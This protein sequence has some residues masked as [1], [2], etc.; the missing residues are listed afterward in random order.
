[1]SFITKA[2]FGSPPPAPDYA[3]AAQVQGQNNIAAAQKEA[4]LNRLNE[5]TPYGSVNYFQGGDGQPWS[6]QISLSPGQQQLYDLE[7]GNQIASQQ[8]AQ[9]LQGRL[10]ASVGQP[11]SF[12][13]IG[14]SQGLDK[15]MDFAQFTG[16][17]PGQ[18]LVDGG[19]RMGRVG[20]GPDPLAVENARARDLGTAANYAGGSDAVRDALYRQ[21]SRLRE[22]D[23]DR[24]RA[25]LDL[26]LRNQGLLPG[27]EIYDQELSRLQRSHGLERNDLADRAILA[28]GA[29]QSRLAGLDMNL[30]AQ[31][32][33]QEN[34][35]FQNR[36]GQIGQAFGQNLQGMGFNNAAAQAEFG[37]RLSAAGF[38]NAATQRGFE[39]Q[40]AALGFNNN[41]S[42][43][44]FD[45]RA[46]AAGF[47]NTNRMNALQEALMLRNQPL[48]E[49]NAFRTGNAPT[50]PQFQPYALGDIAPVNS[51]GA[52][53][54]TYAANTNSYNAKVAQ[55]Q[56]LLNFGAKF[57]GAGGP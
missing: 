48:A 33:G 6:R 18:E 3:A 40:L 25:G 41:A 20:P 44:E 37:N 22:P 2:L 9:G 30:N 13:N 34:Q 8:V 55:M 39:N 5:V 50:M 43:Q 42:V 38:N 4:E 27:T 51:Y 15:A 36:L 24:D 28:A 35:V 53:R 29:E 10:G 46:K 17:L 45:T 12:G 56:A 1:M 52:V 49:F 11:F 19:P 7:T 54:D 31:R 21:Q 23:M 47:N 32:F 14:Q 57:A 26:R 16:A